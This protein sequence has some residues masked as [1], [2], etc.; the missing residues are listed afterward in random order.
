ML[1]YLD[2]WLLLSSSEE[3]AVHARDE[4]L[5]LCKQLGIVINLEKSNLI[6]KQGAVYLGM[7]I[8]SVSLRAFPMTK[9]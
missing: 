2:D 3:G 9:R 7:E 4:T 5:R 6:P 1:R 8:D